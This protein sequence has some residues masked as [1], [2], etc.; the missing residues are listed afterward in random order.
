MS[1]EKKQRSHKQERE[2]ST[3]RPP[4]RCPDVSRVLGKLCDFEAHDFPGLPEDGAKR[5]EP[6]EMAEDHRVPL[7]APRRLK[8][9]IVC[10]LDS[11]KDA[12]EL[13]TRLSFS[14]E[15]E[16]VA[17]PGCRQIPAAAWQQLRDAKW[18]RLKKAN[19]NEFLAREKNGYCIRCLCVFFTVCIES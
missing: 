12:V 2:T 1:L 18:P 5:P 13:M 4:Q 6:S 19:F 14:H 10:G 3:K 9:V 11:D 7:A 16:V 17:F 8:T 15:L